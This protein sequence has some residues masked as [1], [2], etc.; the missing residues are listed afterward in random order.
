[1]SNWRGINPQRWKSTFPVETF[2]RTTLTR[3]RAD[4][5]SFA[6]AERVRQIAEYDE[7][8]ERLQSMSERL[9]A[10]DRT[11]LVAAES[12]L[13][14]IV[15]GPLSLEDLTMLRET[16]KSLDLAAHVQA[17]SDRWFASASL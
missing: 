10:Q 12:V 3:S 7:I 15:N 17:I 5:S 16:V 9:S 1:M 6:D 14:R 11:V 2:R 8:L 4:A 13:L